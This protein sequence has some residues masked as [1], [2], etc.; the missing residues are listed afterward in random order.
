METRES[1]LFTYK[2]FKDTALTQALFNIL[3]AGLAD[4]EAT[5]TVGHL[6]KIYQYPGIFGKGESLADRVLDT[7]IVLS[8]AFQSAL[9]SI[10]VPSGVASRYL[11]KGSGCKG[12][13]YRNVL[14][15]GCGSKVCPACFTQNMLTAHQKITDAYS[16]DCVIVTTTLRNKVVVSKV[17]QEF[18]QASSKSMADPA[19]ASSGYSVYQCKVPHVT[20]LFGA[21]AVAYSLI[22][23]VPQNNLDKYLST[24]EKYKRYDISDSMVYLN[25]DGSYLESC[26]CYPVS[27]LYPE[28]KHI[29]EQFLIHS[30]KARVKW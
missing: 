30:G 8:S 29:L 21:P 27:L 22:S 26:F 7:E 4:R 3:S 15:G 6:N 5:N 17:E 28:N 14:S 1:N 19:S 16:Q 12:A 24:V 23:V 20:D 10:S 9:Q 18:T 11:G 2:S 13:L 25:A